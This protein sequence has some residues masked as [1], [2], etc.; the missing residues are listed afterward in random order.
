MKK[1]KTQVGKSSGTSTRFF[2]AGCLPACPYQKSKSRGRKH[3]VIFASSQ[4]KL[5]C[6][7]AWP[8]SPLCFRTLV[9]VR[10][11]NRVL[12]VVENRVVSALSKELL[13]ETLQVRVPAGLVSF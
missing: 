1:K 7:S 5:L 11:D 2:L 9:Q 4:P 3:S 8:L 12:K 10:L 13:I 6:F